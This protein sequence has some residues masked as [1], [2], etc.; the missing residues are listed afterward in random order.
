MKMYFLKSSLL[1]VVVLSQL[2]ASAMNSNS[3]KI[4]PDTNHIETVEPV[5]F[6][7]GVVPVTTTNNADA[8]FA[9]DGR[10]LY[11]YQAI[12]NASSI[13][14]SKLVNGKWT[15]PVTAPFSGIYGDLEESLSPG[16]K[17]M[18]FASSRP[19]DPSGKSID[20]HYDGQT[21]PGNGG[22]IW[23]IKAIKNGWGKPELLPAN[24]N[25]NTSVF[26]PN[27]A[28]NGDLYF[29]RSDSGREFHLYLSKMKKGGYQTPELF[30]F[31]R[32]GHGD[33]DPAIAPDESF[34]VFSSGRPPA[35]THTADLFIVFRTADG[36]GEPIDLRM[37]SPNIHGIEAR[38]SPDGKTLY[39]SNSRNPS[40]VDVPGDRYIWQVDIS[41]VLKAHGVVV[42]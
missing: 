20:G 7:P 35:P 32:P 13:A 8:V 24:I 1:A 19:D 23:K 34:I 39:F 12:N 9:P 28:A 40:G 25:S 22:R 6:A 38:L 2:N 37:L 30:P 10:T 31:N 41:G 16:G 14:E 27:V 17:Y 42:K 29:M 18:V 33:Y 3:I 36:W 4:K 26:S 21:R 5:I 11:L 15:V